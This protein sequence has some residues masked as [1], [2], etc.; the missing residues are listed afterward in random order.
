MSNTESKVFITNLAKYN[1]G[2]LVGE[3]F[4]LS[5]GE[6]A[7]SKV[8]KKVLGS[9]EEYFIT[10]YEADFE[11][12]EYD[13]LN[14]LV[15]FGTLFDELNE[16]EQT[17]VS[18]YLDH[19]GLDR[20]EVLEKMQND[21][22]MDDCIIYEADNERELGYAI[23]ECMDIPKHLEMWI[24]YEAIGRSEVYNGATQVGDYFIISN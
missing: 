18:Y 1:A 7:L 17:V 4:T 15:E 9:D 2:E 14:E 10:D 23:A 22:L 13:N 5:E 11:I 6:E 20:S 8:L 24:D 19:Y 12:S 3:W 16:M 21:S